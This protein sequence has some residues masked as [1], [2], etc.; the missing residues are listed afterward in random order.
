MTKKLGAYSR[1]RKTYLTNGV[2]KTAQQKKI[3]YTNTVFP[4]VQDD[5]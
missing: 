2:E 4:G 5:F 3:V 1:A